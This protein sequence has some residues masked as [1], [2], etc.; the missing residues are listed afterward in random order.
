MRTAQALCATDRGRAPSQRQSSSPLRM[1]SP[2]RWTSHDL[3]TTR[4][5]PCAERVS[6][7]S[8]AIRQTPMRGG[9]SAAVPRQHRRG[10]SDRRRGGRARRG[11]VRSGRTARATAPAAGAVQP[12]TVSRSASTSRSTRALWSLRRARSRP[13]TREVEATL[14]LFGVS[15]FVAS[16]VFAISLVRSLNAL[17]RHSVKLGNHAADFGERISFIPLD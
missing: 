1:A 8:P 12:V 13:A 3:P 17:H 7:R 10:R 2:S 11:A 15:W 14:L 4:G 5:S 16:L 9:V 6:G